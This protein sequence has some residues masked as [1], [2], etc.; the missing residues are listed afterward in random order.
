MC[1]FSHKDHIYQTGEVDLRMYIPL[2]IDVHRRLFS[3][4][5]CLMRVD[6]IR[7]PCKYTEG[8]CE[9]I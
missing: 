9:Y 6:E 2:T 1:V 7:K 5:F 8:C 4:C 3:D